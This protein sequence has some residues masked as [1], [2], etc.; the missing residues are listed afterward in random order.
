[1]KKKWVLVIILVIAL[2]IAWRLFVRFRGRE[3]DIPRLVPDS[4]ALY[5][6]V[7]DAEGLWERISG[8]GFWQGLIISPL[9]KEAR[10]EEKLA[11]FRQSLGKNGGL[12]LEREN[13]MELIG[14][15]LAVA[16]VSPR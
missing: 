8:S 13:L 6:E 5:I 11:T 4:A 10:I 9:W 1:M 15:D 12:L 3:V 2:F 14:E 16:L 7:K